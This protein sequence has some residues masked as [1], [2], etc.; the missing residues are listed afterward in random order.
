[1][2][3]LIVSD[4][5]GDID[6]FNDVI[7]REGRF[8]MV[9]HCGDGSGEADYFEKRADCPV[10]AVKGNCDLF[11]REPIT[12][13]VT[14]CG[15]RLYVEHGVRICGFERAEFDRFAR[16]NNVDAILY[17]H[18]HRQRLER[19]DRT[20]IINPG[21]LARPRDGSKSYVILT[22]GDDGKME[23][24]GKTLF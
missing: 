21:S 19:T 6:Y 18:T 20:W 16:D 3:I 24:E 22:V 15:K 2:R 23:F 13:I 1:M 11:S 12:R 17:G 10:Y 4:T 8:D 14:V 5:H 9:I 7:G